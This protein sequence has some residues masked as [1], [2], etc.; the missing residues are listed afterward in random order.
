MGGTRRTLWSWLQ[1]NTPQHLAQAPDAES[2]AVQRLPERTRQWRLGDDV[3]LPK[4]ET[5]S[6]SSLE[7]FIYGPYLWVL[8]Y[9][10]RLRAGALLALSDEGRLKGNLAHRLFEHYFIEHPDIPT[11]DVH[12]IAPWCTQQLPNL[13]NTEGASLWLPGKAAERERFITDATAAL[14]RLVEHLQSADVVSVAMETQAQGRFVG[15]DLTG[16]LD[17]LARCRNGQE[18]VIDIKWGGLNY[19]REAL[20]KSHYLQLALYAK[21]REAQTHRLPAVGYYVINRCALLM[22]DTDRF[23]QAE[24]IR[25]DNGETLLEFWRRFELSWKQRRGQL[26]RGQIEVAVSGTD[27]DDG[28]DWDAHCLPLFEKFESFSEFE[29]LVGWE[30]DA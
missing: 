15:G 3:A 16:S 29:A 4:R 11:L 9:L 21:L 13:L 26:D 5:E 17:L 24:S 14:Q 18:A 12:A 20:Q 8:R 28:P 25:P 10:A 22:L 1:G 7:S 2:H 30:Q 19:R 6:Y 27:P 23:P